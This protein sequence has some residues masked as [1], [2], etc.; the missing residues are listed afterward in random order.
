MKKRINVTIPEEVWLWASQYS[1]MNYTSLSALIT[2]LLVEK[3]RMNIKIM[4]F[5]QIQVLKERMYYELIRIGNF[6]K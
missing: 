5:V 6:T 3:R 4:F 1:K 2:S